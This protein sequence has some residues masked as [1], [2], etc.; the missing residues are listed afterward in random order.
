MGKS[1]F[2]LFWHCTKYD[3]S[4][5]YAPKRSLRHARFGRP[6]TPKT[7]FL[8][9]IVGSG[10]IKRL[11]QYMVAYEGVFVFAS[12]P[13]I[14]DQVVATPSEGFVMVVP[15]LIDTKRLHLP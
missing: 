4:T 3:L 5:D 14:I 2:T 6:N 7:P 8:P 9:S 12:D 13:G 15:S 1:L 10:D 11:G